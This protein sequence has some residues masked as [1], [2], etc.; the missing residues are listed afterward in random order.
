MATTDIM[1]TL[2][3]VGDDVVAALVDAK[4]Y[5]GVLRSLAAYMQ[6]QLEFAQE[7]EDV[8]MIARL[9]ATIKNLDD[10][11]NSWETGD[12]PE[13]AVDSNS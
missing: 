9:R 5:D 2:N 8:P 3:A 11:C 7:H 10:A 6:K 4:G 1:L 12:V 13:G